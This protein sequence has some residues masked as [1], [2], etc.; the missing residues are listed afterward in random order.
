MTQ[1]LSNEQIAR[2]AHEANRV[3]CLSLED[4]SQKPWDSAPDWQKNSAI[5]GVEFLIANPEAGPEASHNSWLAVKKRE[6]WQYGLVK[7]EKLRQ[8][9]CFVPYEELPVAQQLKDKLFGTIVKGC[10]AL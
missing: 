2:I 10:L 7:N 5:A 6:G 1:A 3:Y 9:P 8:H 4:A